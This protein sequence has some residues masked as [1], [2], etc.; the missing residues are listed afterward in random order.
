M[1]LCCSC[2]ICLGGT[3]RAVCARR[4]AVALRRVLVEGGHLPPQGRVL[5]A[6]DSLP[7]LDLTPL[8]NR[9]QIGQRFC[10]TAHGYSDSLETVRFVERQ[11]DAM[12][13]EVWRDLQKE[14]ARVRARAMNDAVSLSESDVSERTGLITGVMSGHHS[15]ASAPA[16]VSTNSQL[17][18][19]IMGPR[20]RE[21]ASPGDRFSPRGS[22]SPTL[23]DD[24]DE[25]GLDRLSLRSQLSAGAG[26]QVSLY[27]KPKRD[28]SLL[29]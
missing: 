3:Y 4:L 11:L 21:P 9:D 7:C 23:A 2:C 25:D 1:L 15:A 28:L 20:K 24:D 17:R 19:W 10:L 16:L 27:N 5:M 26:G 13:D 29:T 6:G 18:A 12:E 14:R 8:E 22:T